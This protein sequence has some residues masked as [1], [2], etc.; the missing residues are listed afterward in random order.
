MSRSASSLLASGAK[1]SKFWWAAQQTESRWV[2]PSNNALSSVLRSNEGWNVNF[3][4]FLFFFFLPSLS[5]FSSSGSGSPGLRWC[6]SRSSSSKTNL[7]LSK[8]RLRIIIPPLHSP[9][10][11]RADG[12]MSAVHFLWA[13]KAFYSRAFAPHPG[14][15]V[16]HWFS[17]LVQICTL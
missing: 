2:V 14:E 3:L 8:Q 11:R 6:A 4:Y 17:I 15:I 12:R 9:L 1:S 10:Q 16:N 13:S 7:K 5:S